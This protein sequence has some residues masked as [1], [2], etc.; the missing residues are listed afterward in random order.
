MMLM[1]LN[2]SNYFS[3]EA[4]RLYWSNS[5]YKEFLDCE[6][7][8]MAKLRGWS[9]PTT[10][11]LLLGSYVHAHFEGPEALQR[12]KDENPELISTRGRTKGNL[13][14]EYRLA[15]EMIKT[16]ENDALCMFVL[17]GRKEVIMTAEFAGTRWK[18]KMDNYALDRNRFSDIKTVQEIHKENWDPE[19]GY[20]SFVQKNK[21]VTQMALYAEIERIVQGR[22]GWI[23]PIIVAVSKQDPPDKAVI[24]ING[25]DI[26]RELETIESNMPH[27]I[28]VKAGLVKPRRCELCRYCRETKQLNQIIH[29]SDLINR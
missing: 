9:E 14:A 7:R 20:V 6:A 23:E 4:D 21:Y 8:A 25:Y 15:G 1:Q 26:K 22:D 13:K 17:Q 29:Y 12:F 27:L 11:A 5:Q 3:V 2:E 24:G 16:I 19:N 18:I 28:E 10:D